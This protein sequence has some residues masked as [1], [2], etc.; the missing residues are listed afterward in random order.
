MG[1]EACLRGVLGDEWARALRLLIRG[2]FF[3]PSPPC[4]G[5]CVYLCVILIMFL[6]VLNWI[7]ISHGIFD[8]EC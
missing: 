7:R 4:S 8:R 6:R 2:S 5:S 1:M 3:R